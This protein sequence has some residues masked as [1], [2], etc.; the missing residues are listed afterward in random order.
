MSASSL[1]PGHPAPKPDETFASW[2]TRVAHANGLSAAQLL[3]IALPG[4]HLFSRDL[5][6]LAD[7]SLIDALAQHTG[8]GKGQI[9]ATTF[10][11]YLG[12]LLEQDDGISKLPWIAPV[13]RET[14]RRS[15]G[16]QF[17]PLCSGD[18]VPYL[19]RAWRLGFVT[20]CSRH[21]VLM[22][23]RCPKCGCPISPTSDRERGSGHILCRQCQ[24]PLRRSPTQTVGEADLAIQQHLLEV[25]RDGWIELGAY[26]PVHSLA[27]FAILRLVFRLLATGRHA[28]ALRRMVAHDMGDD[29]TNYAAIPRIRE[30]EYLNPHCRHHLLRLTCHLM[31]DW[32][33]RFVGAIDKGPGT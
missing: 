10:A 12:K 13:G 27:A 6:R 1:W 28:Q 33:T 16:Q 21:K 11:P 8:L 4:T 23:D 7:P 19:R 26:G 22:L 24:F 18:G 2:F 25:L 14:S 15:F 3:P 20:A 17:C 31:Q 30:I 29:E 9:R 32:P 5:D